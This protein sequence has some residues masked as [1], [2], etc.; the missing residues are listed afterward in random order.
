MHSVSLRLSSLQVASAVAL[1]RSPGKPHPEVN[2]VA[3]LDPLSERVCGGEHGGHL[4][5]SGTQMPPRLTF[6]LEGADLNH[7]FAMR[8]SPPQRR[9]RHRDARLGRFCLGARHDVSRLGRCDD[10]VARCFL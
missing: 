7:P 9:L 2:F 10:D 5:L 1:S 3:L 6:V 4:E 8:V